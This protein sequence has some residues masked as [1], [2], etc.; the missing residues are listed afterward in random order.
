MARHESTLN[1]VKGPHR[2]DIRRERRQGNAA[3]VGYVDGN[4][5]VTAPRADVAARILIKKHIDRV[6][7][8]DVISFARARNRVL[9]S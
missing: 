3:Y 2:F 8:A 5:S 6:P 4:R 7:A 1:F 9:R